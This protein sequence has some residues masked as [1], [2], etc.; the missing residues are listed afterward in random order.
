[1]PVKLSK[2]SPSFFISILSPFLESIKILIAFFLLTF[3]YLIDPLNLTLFN[4]KLGD[5]YSYEDWFET[6]DLTERFEI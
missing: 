3:P 6:L 2:L 1:M 4:T 5:N